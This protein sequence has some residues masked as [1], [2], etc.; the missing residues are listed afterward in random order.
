MADATRI[1]GIQLKHATTKHAQ[2]IGILERCHASL[3]ELL[4]ITT[5]ERRTMWHQYVAIATLNYNTSYHSALGCEPSRVFHGRIPYNVLDLKFGKRSGRHST[6]TTNPGED[7]LHKTQQIKKTVRKNLMQFYIRYKQY[8][9]KKA[10][11][12]PST[13]TNTTTHY[14]PGQIARILKSHS[15]NISGQ[16]PTSSSKCFN[17]TITLS[18]NYRRIIGK[19]F[20]GSV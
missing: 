3:K 13:S 19:F 8:Y 18:E 2:T 12:H 7:I 16:D 1:L 5:G 10:N 14:T 20:I 6:S 11:S 17:L 4:K 15:E 9:D